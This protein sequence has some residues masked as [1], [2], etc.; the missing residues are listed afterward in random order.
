ML[1]DEP[2]VLAQQEIEYDWSH[3]FNLT[4]SDFPYDLCVIT[5][6]ADLEGLGGPL[7]SDGLYF[8]RDSNWNYSASVTCTVQLPAGSVLTNVTAAIEKA[9]YYYGG[10]N[11]DVNGVTSCYGTW[12]SCPNAAFY[13]GAGNYFDA[14]NIFNQT[15]TLSIGLGAGSNGEGWRGS[16]R[17]ITLYGTGLDP[18][19]VPLTPTATPTGV[20]CGSASSLSSLT[21]FSGDTC[22][23]PGLQARYFDGFS[24]LEEPVIARLDPG[25]NFPSGEWDLTGLANNSRF[26]VQWQGEIQFNFPQQPDV[27][28]M[29]TPALLPNSL[30]LRFCFLPPESV[31]PPP[32]PTIYQNVKLWIDNTAVVLTPVG[33]EYCGD[34]VSQTLDGSWHAV[35]IEFAYF[36]EPD[37]DGN[38][39]LIWTWQGES[40]NTSVFAKTPVAGTV[41]RPPAAL[42]ETV[43]ADSW[44]EYADCRDEDDTTMVRLL[45]IYPGRSQEATDMYSF[46]QDEDSPLLDGEGLIV[47]DGPTINA[48]RLGILPWD[49]VVQVDPTPWFDFP[50][51]DA[52]NQVDYPAWVWYRLVDNETYTDAWIAARITSVE[53]N[54]EGVSE[55]KTFN[56]VVG[57]G[58]EHHPCESLPEFTGNV[59][60]EYNRVLAAE[61]GIANAY[62]NSIPYSESGEFYPT[63]INVTIPLNSDILIDDQPIPYVTAVPYAY[64][65]YSD[66]SGVRG[67][68]GSAVFNSQA[69]WMGGLPMTYDVDQNGLAFLQQCGD[70]LLYDLGGWR[71]CNEEGIETGNSTKVWSNH[72]GIVCYYSNS[73]EG[74]NF[75]CGSIYPHN[76]IVLPPV[77]HG[78]YITTFEIFNPED[79][80]RRYE[81]LSDIVDQLREGGGS[82]LDQQP[83]QFYEAL[84][85]PS[86]ANQEHTINGITELHTGDYVFVERSLASNAGHGYLIVG[87]GQ[88]SSCPTALSNIWSFSDNPDHSR[89]YY[90]FEQAQTNN[91]T[92]VV[93]Y[94]VDFPGSVDSGNQTQR[95]RPRPFYCADYRDPQTNNYQLLSDG[96]AFFTFPNAVT[97]PVSALYTSPD[98][99]WE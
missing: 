7:L 38:P 5:P 78:R 73:P 58:E 66:V 93:P 92:Y 45:P 61:Y 70:S 80:Y 63:Q 71:F 85:N 6:P 25:I 32:D 37:V 68:T 60:F 21:A 52:T 74:L 53:L 29:P 33:N 95:P 87:W 41:L 69:I 55:P 49:S 31:I 4:L 15:G 57:A 94:V 54:D 18:F 88:I 34:L 42:S 75:P 16:I 67:A 17:S 39:L 9:T 81:W 23:T 22:P 24:L 28:P 86:S 44:F 26:F 14:N 96:F 10:I 13:W 65:P 47:H 62:R 99:T 35:Q 64:F 3:I 59:T 56:Y 46:A 8:R 84:I 30:T 40:A 97:L 12:Y 19:A 20:V 1:E 91:V 83:Q 90:S 43:L 98:W 2:L 36:A 51:R 48:G 11:L 27:T 76:N 72:R 77:Q 82:N 79:E 89:L 50:Q